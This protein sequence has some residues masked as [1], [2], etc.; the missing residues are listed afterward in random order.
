MTYP[1]PAGPWVPDPEAIPAEIRDRDQ[2]VRFTLVPQE[3]KK[4]KKVPLRPSGS[5]AASS[6]DPSTWGSFDVARAN[7]GRDGAVGIGYVFTVEDPYVGI[8]FDDVLEDGRLH[9]AVAPLVDDLAT[10]TEVSPSGCG[11][12]LFGR[13]DHPLP[14]VDGH[15]RPGPVGE[16]EW[17]QAE[18]YFTVTGNLLPGTPEDIRPVN[19]ALDAILERY[20][21]KRTASPGEDLPAGVPELHDDDAAALAMRLVSRATAAIAG[22]A[23]RHDTIRGALLQARHNR[24]PYEMAERML[25][26][27]L[28]AANAI[29][30]KEPYPLAQLQRLLRD[31][32]W[33]KVVPGEPWTETKRKLESYQ[34]EDDAPAGP[35]WRSLTDVL[36]LA[37]PRTPIPTGFS[38]LDSTFLG[39]GLAPGDAVAVGGP[40]G[41]GKTTFIAALAAN[42]AGPK[43]HVGFAAF[44]EPEEKVAAKVGARFGEAFHRLNADYPS[45][46]ESL[47]ERLAIKDATIEF[48]DPLGGPDVETI[49][50]TF[51]A[52]VPAGKVGVLFLDHLHLLESRDTTDR[53]NEFD[54]VR[55][56]ATAVAV[57]T[58]KLGLITVSIAEVLKAASS[59]D[60][61]RSNPLGAFAGT[62]KIASLFTVP[63][64]MV[65]AEGGGF[66]LILAKNRL[67]P[68]GSAILNVNF[69]TWNVTV[70]SVRTA[71]RGTGTLGEESRTATVAKAD[72]DALRAF[73]AESEPMSWND[74]EAALRSRGVTRDRALSARRRLTMAGELVETPG[75]RPVGVTRGFVP[76]FWTVPGKVPESPRKSPESLPAGEFLSQKESPRG[77][78][79]LKGR[80]GTFSGRKA[81][82]QKPKKPT[83]SRGLS[84]PS[85]GA[86]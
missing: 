18:R 8:D 45:V 48:V 29:P 74:A 17:Y 19:G 1:Y 55:K 15:K 40:P 78:P 39:G 58:R 16:I 75:V 59:P 76:S 5:G 68:R 44:D 31:F 71:S 20:F 54:T 53:D 2:W 57:L 43:T 51:A 27:L 84:A 23:K 14:A 7:I 70:D 25:P 72:D 3:G 33:A 80:A 21:A 63:M 85:G 34:E 56:V 11:V 30:G 67:G 49:L 64:V 36:L 9:P 52:R 4:P 35:T 28:D 81:K 73:F 13:R 60:A 66:E 65:P 37:R 38:L 50:E 26:A 22:G 79:P 41:A 32:V 12:K 47:E 46:L 10:Y 61:V 77:A 62:R 82:S 86:A 42:L 83:S 24:V 69:E 6:T